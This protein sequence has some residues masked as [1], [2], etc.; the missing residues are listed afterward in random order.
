[1]K[2]GSV[3]AFAI[4]LGVVLFA[5]IAA[6]ARAGSSSSTRRGDRLSPPAGPSAPPGSSS[7]FHAPAGFRP[8]RSGESTTEIQPAVA[9]LFHTGPDGWSERTIGGTRY[10]F[11][12]QSDPDGAVKVL[13]YRYD[14]TGTLTPYVPLPAALD[15]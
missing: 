11:Y 9:E 14:P 7:S 2:R 10:G 13:P 6:A 1:M 4:G 3:L 12:T 15:H 8:L 5:A